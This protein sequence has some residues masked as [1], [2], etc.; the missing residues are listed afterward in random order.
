M[1]SWSLAKIL[2]HALQSGEAGLVYDDI[3][4]G[5]TTWSRIGSLPMR[6]LLEKYH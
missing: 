1:R 4:A 2:A 5:M 3:L 6:V